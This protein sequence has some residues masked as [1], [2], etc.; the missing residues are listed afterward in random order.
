MWTLTPLCH[1]KI[2]RRVARI[3]M[4]EPGPPAPAESLQRKAL[5]MLLDT[6]KTDR[7]VVIDGGFL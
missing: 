4:Y 6:V 2:L 1:P 5:G 7:W 3:A